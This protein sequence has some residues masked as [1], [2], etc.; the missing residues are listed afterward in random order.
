MN[1]HG[2]GQRNLT[3][4]PARDGAPAWSPDGRTI[5]FHSSRDR[6]NEIYVMHA[7]GSGQRNLTRNRY[8]D[9]SF[10]WSPAQNE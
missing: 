7:D 9:F 3:R 2:S 1:A 5:A 4:N 6:N 8:H 10:A